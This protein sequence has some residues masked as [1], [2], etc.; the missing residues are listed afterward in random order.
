[1]TQSK[2]VLYMRFEPK[3]SCSNIHERREIKSESVPGPPGFHWQFAD[4][5]TDTILQGQSITTS[6][7]IISAAGNF[8]LGFFSPGNSTNYYVGIWYKKVSD[9]TIVWVAN[10]DYAFKNP[11]VVLTVST[12]GNLEILEGKFAYKSFD[13]PSHAFLPGMKIGYDK[14]AGK[15]WS[16]TSWK[17]TE[18][19]S[20]GPG[21]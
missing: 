20:P 17:S 8:E 12:D 13:Y 6:Q 1:M 5:F 11:S 21:S 9:K 15:T 7:T 2:V 18:D 14:R 16:L 10:R 4:A 19:P 3:V